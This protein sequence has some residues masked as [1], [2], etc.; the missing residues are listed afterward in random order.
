MKFIIDMYDH[1][2]LTRCVGSYGNSLLHCAAQSGK[3][4]MVKFLI[5]QGLDVNQ[6]NILSETPL[7]LGAGGY[8]KGAFTMF[9]KRKTFTRR[10]LRVQSSINVGC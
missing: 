10:T 3:I 4:E 9:L 1:C 5:A 8:F 6:R 7:H 2:D